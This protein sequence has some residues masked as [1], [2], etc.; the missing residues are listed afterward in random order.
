MAYKL[1]LNEIQHR[2]VYFTFSVLCTFATCYKHSNSFVYSF[3]KPLILLDKEGLREFIFTTVSEAFRVNITLA[4]IFTMV[5]LLPLFFYNLVVFLMPAFYQKNRKPFLHILGIGL[6]GFYLV[7]IFVF[8]FILPQ[9]CQ[10]FLYFEEHG[11]G[12]LTHISLEASIYSYT[13][14]SLSCSY[15][16]LF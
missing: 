2:L 5:F 7:I 4:S 10:F 3:T 11:T 6:F 8:V 16:F 1:I 15:F 14:F 9:V 13:L 12:T